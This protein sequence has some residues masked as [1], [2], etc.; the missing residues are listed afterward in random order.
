M[1]E[2]AASLQQ[3]F[4]QAVR[5]HGADSTQARDAELAALNFFKDQS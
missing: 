5:L 2:T 1:N 3:E 4:D